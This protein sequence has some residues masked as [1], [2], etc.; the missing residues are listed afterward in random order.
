MGFFSELK[1]RNVH[2]VAVAYAALAWLVVEVTHTV[3]PAL[4]LPGW[5]L[6]WVIWI[7]VV[8]FPVTA[9][10]CWRYEL[11]EQGLVR[12]RGQNRDKP[13][14]YSVHRINAIITVLLCLILALIVFEQI[15]P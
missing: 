3:A 13:H 15:Q 5:V 10:L 8:G 2:R 14:T 7:G 9:W 1:R 11:T 4:G 6:Q 12:D